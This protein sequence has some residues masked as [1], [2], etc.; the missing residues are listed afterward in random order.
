MARTYRALLDAMERRNYDV[1]SSRVRVSRWRKLILLGRSLPAQLG[2]ERGCMVSQ[3]VLIIGGGLAGLA[4]ATALAPRGFRVTHSGIAQSSRRPGQLVSRSP[5]PASWSTPASTSAWAAAPTWPIFAAPWASTSI[6]QPQPCLYFMT[7]DGRISRFRADA[8]PAPF[9][10][11]RSFVASHY[12][13]AVEKLRIAWG[14]VWLQRAPTE[15]DPP[16]LD[17]LDQAPPDAAHHRP[18]LGPGADQ[19]PQREPATGSACAMPARCSS[20]AS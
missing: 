20:T 19:R 5:P 10:L 1:F 15:D 12:L 2:M 11:S 14:L 6:W 8:W 13:T 3:E 17:W 16:F 4:A 9:H 7:P 18:L